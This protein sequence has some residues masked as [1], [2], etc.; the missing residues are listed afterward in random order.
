MQGCVLS[1]APGGQ[2]EVGLWPE[3]AASVPPGGIGHEEA[4]VELNSGS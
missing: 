3:N 4:V 1:P 2:E